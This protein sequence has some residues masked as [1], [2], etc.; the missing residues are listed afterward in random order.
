MQGLSVL[1]PSLAGERARELTVIPEGA[2]GE[3]QQRQRV[4]WK[5]LYRKV[6]YLLEVN[7][8]AAGGKFGNW[9][10]VGMGEWVEEEFGRVVVP[11]SPGLANRRRI[12]GVAVKVAKE[13]RRVMVEWG[14]AREGGEEKVADREV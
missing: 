10:Y 7:P 1:V 11:R 9:S 2:G 6:Q 14:A 8:E 3:G 4:D 13:M 12:W 5:G